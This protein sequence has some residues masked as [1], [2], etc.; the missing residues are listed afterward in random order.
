MRQLYPIWVSM[1]A[2]AITQVLKPIL[3]YL[4]HKKW[5]LRLLFDSGGLPSSHSSMVTSLVLSVGLLEDFSSTIFAV[6][7]VFAFIT[8]Y[9]AANVRYYAG[10]NIQLTRKLI[11]DLKA[12]ESYIQDLDD[13]IYDMRIKEILGHKWFEVFSGALLGLLIA[14]LSYFVFKY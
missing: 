6:T 4:L 9:D 2:M 13:P 12:S 10:K 3:F 5:N 14:G 8:M 11:T 1:A 7:V